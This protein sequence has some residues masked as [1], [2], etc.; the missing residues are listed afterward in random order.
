MVA[1]SGVRPPDK[2]PLGHSL[3]QLI[4]R[5]AVRDTLNGVPK[6]L[7]HAKQGGA[8]EKSSG[9]YFVMEFFQPRVYHDSAVIE[10]LD[11]AVDRDER[12]EQVDH[13]DWRGRLWK[14]WSP[15]LGVLDKNM[16]HVPGFDK[17]LK[18]KH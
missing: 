10:R 4:V 14:Y 6:H 15:S 1:G 2:A 7:R 18:M 8:E 16:C 9:S 12:L 5:L 13:P 11:E 17:K 3:L